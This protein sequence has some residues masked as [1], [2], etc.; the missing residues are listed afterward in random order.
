MRHIVIN[1]LNVAGAIAETFRCETQMERQR[2]NKEELDATATKGLGLF[3]RFRHI[4]S[5]QAS[6][7]F[8]NKRK[9][10]FNLPILPIYD[11]AIA[12]QYSI[13]G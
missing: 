1:C 2:E 13:F 6:S 5:H 3:F 8:A 4:L 9:T 12:V 10:P 7:R 11:F